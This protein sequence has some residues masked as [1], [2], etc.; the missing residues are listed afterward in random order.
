MPGLGHTVLV[1]LRGYRQAVELPGKTRGEVADVDHLL[2]FAETFGLDLADLDRNA[3]TSALSVRFP[4]LVDC[5]I[6]LTD[7]R[8]SFQGLFQ[9]GAPVSGRLRT[10]RETQTMDR[11]VPHLRPYLANNSV[12]S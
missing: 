2:D 7:M 11:H 10:S 3:S 9:R 8:D 4:A 12:T 6:I 1:A 5:F